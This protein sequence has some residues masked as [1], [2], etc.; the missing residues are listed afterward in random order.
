MLHHPT[1]PVPGIE[2]HPLFPAEIPTRSQNH[3]CSSRD[4]CLQTTL[5][6]LNSD[7][8]HAQHPHC[9]CPSITTV[10]QAWKKH[11]PPD[12]RHL[13]LP[14]LAPII[15]STS[16]APETVL[17][18]HLIA[19]AQL[20]NHHL[21]L[22]L[23]TAGLALQADRIRA[24]ATRADRPP[25]QVETLALLNLLDSVHNDVTSFLDRSPEEQLTYPAAASKAVH[26]S[27][28]ACLALDPKGLPTLW[29]SRNLIA[30]L[31]ETL[32]TDAAILLPYQRGGSYLDLPIRRLQRNTLSTIRKMATLR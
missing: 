21:P 18:R 3:E 15:A 12:D 2:D 6:W 11:L 23:E 22:W 8:Q 29:P 31:A 4:Q 24:H 10:I 28:T 30:N 25:T 26:R 7:E 5:H 13:R 1:P 14:P 20:T 19:V 17:K 16:A 32:T 27:G 9:I